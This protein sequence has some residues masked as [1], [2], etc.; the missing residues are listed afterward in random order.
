MTLH[1]IHINIEHNFRYNQL[2]EE[3]RTNQQIQSVRKPTMM[4]KPVI[5][6]YLG[7]LLI[8]VGYKLAGSQ[9]TT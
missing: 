7:N 2:R 6:Y 9:A 8:N 5:S 4:I 1:P 3:A